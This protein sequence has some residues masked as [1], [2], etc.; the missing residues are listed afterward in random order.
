MR[1]RPSVTLFVPTLNEIDGM[2]TVMPGVGRDWVDQILV[3]DGGSTDGTVEYARQQGY[4]VYVQKEK[5]L[6]KGYNEAWPLIQGEIVITFSPDGNCLPEAIPRLVQKMTE[7]YDM[8]VASRYLDGARSDDDNWLTAFGNWLFTHG[9]I[10]FLHGGSYSDAMGIYRAYK[11]Q[12]FYG[13]GIDQDESYLPWER[14]WR[15]V[16]GV[17]PLISTRGAKRKLR[18]AEI[19]ANE[20]KRLGGESKLLVIQWGGAYFCQI[21][22]ELW[23]WK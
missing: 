21:L 6:R 16:M 14:L 4:D 11:T 3:M 12:L 2:R 19:P 23:Y 22:R 9:L 15:T 1:S 10:N 17:E 8:V 20:P 18:I 13:L 7:G 5:G